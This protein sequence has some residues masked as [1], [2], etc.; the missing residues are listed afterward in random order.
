[1]S[2]VTHVSLVDDLDGTEAAST[3]LFEFDGRNYEIDLSEANRDKLDELLAD[4]IAHARRLTRNKPTKAKSNGTTSIRKAIVTS[5][6]S[7]TQ[8]TVADPPTEPVTVSR[9][10]TRR[11]KAKSTVEAPTFAAEPRTRK[12]ASA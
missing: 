7:T 3:T 1:M 6:K 12:R 8:A 4:Y 5:A 10:T 2:S 9:P 11:T